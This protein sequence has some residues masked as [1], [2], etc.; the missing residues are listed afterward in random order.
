MGPGHAGQA[1]VQ[2][3]PFLGAVCELVLV[4]L[5]TPCPEK[6]SV[7]GLE[8]FMPGRE[9]PIVC[10]VGARETGRSIVV[11]DDIP[12]LGEKLQLYTHR[13]YRRLVGGKRYRLETVR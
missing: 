8:G 13:Q 6:V 11:M 12:S 7:V 1:A 4:A 3:V 9:Y 2:Y 10:L 5:R